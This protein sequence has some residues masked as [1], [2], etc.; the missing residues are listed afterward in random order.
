[1]KKIVF[2]ALLLFSVTL[3]ASHAAVSSGP[4][5]GNGGANF[6]NSV[7]NYFSVTQTDVNVVRAKGIPDEEIPVVFFLAKEAK[8]APSTIMN[9]RKKGKSWMGITKRFGYGPEIYYISIDSNVEI[10][11]PYDRTL[12]YFNSKPKKDWNTISLRD[13]EII[14]LVNLKFMSKFFKYP[15]EN[16][17]KMRQDNKG[18]SAISDEIVN[19]KNP[20]HATGTK[21]QEGKAKKFIKKI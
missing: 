15:P 8:V 5:A 19:Q 16:I 9:L 18:F 12:G 6:Y 2:L 14:N 21:K 1:M 7:G 17:M 20:D 10:V 3:L 4:S 13:D 11:P